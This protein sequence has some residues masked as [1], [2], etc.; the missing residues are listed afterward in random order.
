L[1][2][3]RNLIELDFYAGRV[4]D[5]GLVHLKNLTKLRKLNL[6]GSTV[7]DAGLDHLVGLTQLEELNLY[8]TGITNAGLEKLKAHPGLRQLE[9]KRGDW[10]TRSA[11]ARLTEQTSAKDQDHLRGVLAPE[12]HPSGAGAQHSTFAMHSYPR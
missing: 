6:L 2:N 11:A 8:R 1:R 5:A 3:L 4:S 9:I 12:L 7:T 10:K